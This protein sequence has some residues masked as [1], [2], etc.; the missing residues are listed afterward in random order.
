MASL[1]KSFHSV[2]LPL[3]VRPTRLRLFHGSRA[4]SV[5]STVAGGS[6]GGG[7]SRVRVGRQGR[8]F[9]CNAVATLRAVQG[10]C[11]AMSHSQYV[12]SV[13]PK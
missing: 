12:I 6:T 11:C 4:S 3:A 1:L 10:Y 13:S 2:A 9:Q 7:W 8:R 5:T